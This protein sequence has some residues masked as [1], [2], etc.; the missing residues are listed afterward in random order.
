MGTISG[1]ITNSEN[2]PMSGVR[3]LLLKLVIKN[4]YD[5]NKTRVALS[6]SIGRYEFK[7][8]EEGDYWVAVQPT[9]PSPDGKMSLFYFPETMSGKDAYVVRVGPNAVLTAINVKCVPVK[10]GF[11]A[12]GS[13]VDSVTRTPVTHLQLTYGQIPFASPRQDVQSDEKGFFAITRLTPG[14]YWAAI[15][16]DKSGNYYCYPAYFEITDA[17][18]SNLQIPVYKGPTLSGMVVLNKGIPET[19]FGELNVVFHPKGISEVNQNPTNYLIDR[20]MEKSS[21]VSVDGRFVIKGL[22]PLIGTLSLQR[23]AGITLDN[24]FVKIEQN[25]INLREGLRVRD[26]DIAGVTITATAGTCKLVGKVKPEVNT[27]LDLQ[28]VHILI[29]LQTESMAP[30]AKNVQPDATGGFVFDGLLPGEYRVMAAI[31]KN[32]LSR[33]SGDIHMVQLQAGGTKEI[34]IFAGN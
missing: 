22:P 6:D 1:R 26:Q 18:V 15:S 29:S 3:V 27:I 20:Y 21:P 13:V 30:F 19:I 8:I 4:G 10:Q 9:E 17:D 14:K 25:G 12:R 7:D 31:T 11:E 32:G 24:Y 5:P 2:Q 34:E 28:S 16:H 33:R 23:R